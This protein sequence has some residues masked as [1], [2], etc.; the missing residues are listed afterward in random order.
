MKHNY[1]NI[2][3]IT[4]IVLIVLSGNV[5]A[6]IFSPKIDSI[7]IVFDKNQLVL[8]GES[9]K[10][11]VISF[12][13]KGKVKKTLGMKGGSVFWWRYKTKVVGGK[14]YGGKITVNQHLMPSK[15]KYI[16]I[17]VAPRRKP[18]LAKT[19][20]IPLNYETKINFAPTTQ[21]DKAPGC[22][23]KGEIISEF[24]NGVV[25][26]FK[27][28]R[29][30]HDMQ[31]FRIFTDGLSYRKGR[32]TIE[33]DFTKIIDHQV[34]LWVTSLRNPE[35]IGSF[36]ILLDYKHNYHL[37]FSGSS[38]FNGFNGTSGSG[39]STGSDGSNGGHGEDGS[40][41]YDGPDVGVWT[42]MYF[43]STLNCRLLYVF[44]EDFY[45]G[46]EFK[47]LVNPD[48]GNLIVTSRGGDGGSGGNGGNGGD[49]GKGAD[50]RIWYE[51][52][53]EKR[54]VSK[55]FNETVT[56]KVK[57]TV[58]NSEG[59][60]EEVE[61]EVTEVI[62]VYR[63]VEEEYEVTIKHQEPGEDGG[64]GGHGGYGGYG[65]HGGYGGNIYLHFTDDAWAF[66]NLIIASAPGGTGGSGGCSGSGGSGGFG[67]YGNPN[68]NSGSNGSSGSNGFSGSHGGNGQIYVNSTEEFFFYKTVAE[69]Q[70]QE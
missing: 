5:N 66:A 44:A 35:I 6:G 26:K 65:G 54:T 67:G 1:F 13:K 63:D 43:D 68:G 3:V 62:T 36:S 56:K 28:L 10:I 25:R 16:S 32:F 47:Y 22:S 11:G 29:T 53:I 38:G 30:K 9:F 37:S 49:G 21:F 34:L 52:K 24:D 20:L 23:F 27:N 8:P 18:K 48:G 19:I 2:S 64:N 55:P 45:S 12:H 51:T 17:N 59:E 57:K 60:P 70:P 40:N 14:N 39:G 46:E 31:N 61:E 50:G 69:K 41:G 4:I 33:S 7:K 58:Y 42:D 15:G